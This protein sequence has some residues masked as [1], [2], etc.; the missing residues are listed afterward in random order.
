M[1]TT[2]HPVL[3]TTNDAQRFIEC[4]GD[5]RRTMVSQID[6]MTLF[7]ISGGRV[8]A[9]Q[10]GIKLPVSSGMAVEVLL[11]ND[12]TYVVRRTFTRKQ[13]GIP[14]TFDHGERTNVYC[15]DLSE[16]C[17]YASCYKSYDATEWQDKA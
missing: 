2:Q 14:V 6:R 4:D 12:D 17:Y 8:V 16:V 13:A 9:T 15:D 1:T 11:A 3:D 5:M 7:S 10:Y